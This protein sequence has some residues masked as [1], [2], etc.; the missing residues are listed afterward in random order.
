VP[1]PIGWLDAK[2]ARPQKVPIE[3]GYLFALVE[4]L[5]NGISKIRTLWLT[6][7]PFFDLTVYPREETTKR[8]YN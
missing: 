3:E 8:M 7:I 1:R 5:K 2:R 4:R 6:I